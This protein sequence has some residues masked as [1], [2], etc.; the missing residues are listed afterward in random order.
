MFEN[1]IQQL[2]Q[3]PPGRQAMLGV[4]AFGSL[5]FLGWIAFGA[6]RPDYRAA[7]RGL[8]EDEIAQVATLLREERIDYEI[9]EGGTA[10]LVPAP[11]VYEARIRAAGR[12][13]PSG[14]SAG[15]ELFDQPAFGVTDFVHRVNYTRAIQGELARS[16][17]QLEPVARARVQVVIPERKSV[18]AAAERKPTAS[19]IAKL[20]PGRQLQPEH[21]RAIVHLVAS[22]IE[23]LDPADVTVVDGS[24][25]LLTADGSEVAGGTLPA[26]GAPSYQQRVEQDLGKRIESMLEKTVGPGGVIAR[27]RADMDWTERETTEESFDPDTQIA[28]S[29]QRTT[30][31]SSEGMGEGGVPG[32]ASNNPDLAATSGGGSNASSNRTSETLNF[33][34]SKKVSREVKPMGE[35]ERLSI[36]VLVAD[37]PPAEEGGDPVPWDDES[38]VL[39]TNLA[40]QAV[41]FDEQRGDQ[42]T[43]NSAPFKTPAAEIPEDGFL[44]PQVLFLIGTVVR[45]LAVALALFLFAKL[46]VTPVLASIEAA[47]PAGAAALPATVAELQG[48]NPEL[49]AR[50][51]DEGP[52]SAV[53]TDDGVQTLRNWLNQS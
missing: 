33:E 52:I 30:E 17:E 3:L 20:Q 38:I 5:L 53:Q 14:G 1:L 49:A 2:R 21:V 40:K 35:I 45:I 31:T 6:A 10:I 43:V 22:G 42:I 25:R 7:Y 29:E 51:L 15:F 9:S 46:V 48:D 24:G 16:V 8:P 44:T 36:A 28:R 19:V 13:L 11:M 34:I 41:G 50:Q 26:G 47:A 27:V 39:F 32:V 18:L 23:S 12:G 4:T 37:S